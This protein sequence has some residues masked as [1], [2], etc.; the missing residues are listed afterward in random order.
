MA[1]TTV[2]GET[3]IVTA[4][5]DPLMVIAATVEVPL[6][7]VKRGA[8]LVDCAA[9]VQ[10]ALVMETVACEVPLRFT[11]KAGV[12]AAL[13]VS[14]M[15][16]LLA[17]A[18]VDVMSVGRFRV[19]PSHDKMVVLFALIETALAADALTKLKPD[20][21]PAKVSVEA[22]PSVPKVASPEHDLKVLPAIAI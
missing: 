19:V 18:V 22:L 14:R 12:P 2:R 5:V 1:L 11:S 4:P 15:K 7:T 9:K 6:Y 3:P 10:K 20:V 17:A 16:V 13:V 21:P 8:R